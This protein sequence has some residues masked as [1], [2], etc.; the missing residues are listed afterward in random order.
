MLQIQLF[1]AETREDTISSL[2]TY[3]DR[4]LWRVIL[5]TFARNVLHGLCPAPQN[6]SSYATV[7]VNISW[8]ERCGVCVYV[9]A[10][11]LYPCRSRSI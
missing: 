5:G 3:L 10:S 8:P 6:Y 1:A 11:V 4:Y 2:P 7:D 9:F